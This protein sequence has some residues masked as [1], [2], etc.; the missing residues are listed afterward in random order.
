MDFLLSNDSDF[1]PLFTDQLIS[2]IKDQRLS[3]KEDSLLQNYASDFR[4][5]IYLNATIG[6]AESGLYKKINN[7]HTSLNNNLIKLNIDVQNDIEQLQNK[8][9][10]TVY[11]TSLIIMVAIFIM[12]L[13]LSQQLTKDVA[14]LN[15]NMK[16]FI[17]QDFNEETTS[18]K[19][20]SDIAEVKSLYT[21]YELLKSKLITT[22]K[23]LKVNIKRANTNAAYASRDSY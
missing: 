4:D 5:L 3:K 15:D 9:G 19:N 12:V 14:V 7:Y 17:E 1:Y 18:P 21:N 23:D 8:Q 11:I 2:I 10:R 13:Y 22:I 20:K 16:S 6:S